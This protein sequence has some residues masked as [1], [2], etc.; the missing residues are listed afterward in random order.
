MLL[1]GDTEQTLSVLP[2]NSVQLIFTSPPYYNA[3]EYSDYSSYDVYLEKMKSILIALHRV[4]EDGRFIVINV[5][6]SNHEASWTGI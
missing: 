1:V 6:P 2:D 4:L 3:R 5:S